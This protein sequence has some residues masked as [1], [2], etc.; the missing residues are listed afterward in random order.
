MIKAS[1]VQVKTVF[2]VAA[3]ILII[4]S[5]FSYIRIGQLIKAA[6]LVDHT[7]EVKL[8]L[9]RTY[10]ELVQAESSQRGYIHSKNTAFLNNF[11]LA[12]ENLNRQIDRADFLT[13]DSPKQQANIQKLRETVEKRNRFMKELLADSEHSPIPSER[14]MV[15]KVIME[16]I[17]QLISIMGREE[18]RLLEMRSSV[19]KSEVSTA[20]LLT[21]SLTIGA[22][23]ILVFAY[24]KILKELKTSDSLRFEVEGRE[25]RIQSIL[26]AAPDAVVTIDKDGIITSWNA[27]AEHIFGWNKDETIGKTLPETIIPNRHHHGHTNGMKRYLST[28]EGPVLNKA[29][30]VHGRTKAGTEVPIELKIAAS[31]GNDSI[32]FIG[33]MRDVSIRKELEDIARKR[34]QEIIEINKALVKTNEELESFA[35]ISSHDLQEPLRHIQ[36]FISRIKDKDHEQLSDNSKKFFSKIESASVRMQALIA[37]LLAYSR[38]NTEAKSFEQTNIEEVIKEVLSELQETIEEKKAVIE[39]EGMCTISTIQYQFQQ[40]LHNLLSNA[41]K[42]SRPDVQPHISIYCKNIVPVAGIHPEII[43]GKTYC[44]ISVTDNGIGFD[45]QYKD[46][47]F[48]VFQRLHDKNTIAGTGIGLAIVKKIVENHNGI[49][50]ASGQP[51]NG[52]RFDIY[53]PVDDHA[54]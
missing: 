7:K 14:W 19:F 12:L 9:E 29:I 54:A 13:K 50:T 20:P 10:V 1:R 16:D 36:T 40:M 53:L 25:Q 2:F 8:S 18:D 48:Q 46:R 47:I 4:L 27:E 37:D 33:F 15:G 49:I 39:I 32:E 45:E 3:L 44:H 17:R 41:L 30:E 42:F 31:E 22:V 23:I 52:A 6:E 43:P 21:I 38:A 51:G 24:I 28:G 11:Y 34:T 26:E 35:Y 5:G